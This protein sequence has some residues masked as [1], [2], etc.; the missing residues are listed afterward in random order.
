MALIG[1]S[2]ELR[3]ESDRLE[4]E[5]AEAELDL[6]AIAEYAAEYGSWDNEDGEQPA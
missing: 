5:L 3:A 4:P 1:A 6:E 2:E